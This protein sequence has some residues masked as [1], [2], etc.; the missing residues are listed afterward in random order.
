MSYN[1][2]L[3]IVVD[4]VVLSNKPDSN[5]EIIDAA[6]KLSLYGFRCVFLRDTLPKKIKLNENDIMVQLLRSKW[7]GLP[8]PLYGTEACNP[9]NKVVKSLDYVITCALL[10]I[11]SCNNPK[12]ITDCKLAFGFDKMSDIITTRRVR[13]LNGLSKSTDM[14]KYL[15]NF[16]L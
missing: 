7:G 6:K 5:F 1:E 13:F 2:I 3:N 8:I 12:V 14:L 9:A 16:L 10:K 4:S 11:F 15:C